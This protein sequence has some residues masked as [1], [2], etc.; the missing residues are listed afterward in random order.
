LTVM[1]NQGRVGRTTCKRLFVHVGCE[2]IGLLENKLGEPVSFLGHNV[3]S[4]QQISVI[5][6]YVS[7]V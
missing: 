5:A 3:R 4:V 1:E 6:A 7:Q 2:R